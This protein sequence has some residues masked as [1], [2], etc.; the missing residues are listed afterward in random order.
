MTW[1]RSSR[2]G[3]GIL[4]CML[5]LLCPTGC[6]EEAQEPPTPEADAGSDVGAVD[7]ADTQT[8]AGLDADAPSA[9]DQ[10]DTEADSEPD[11][12]ADVPLDRQDMGGEDPTED[13]G[14]VRVDTVQ[15]LEHEEIQEPPLAPTGVTAEAKDESVILRWD[16]VV[17]A[18]SYSVYWDTSSGVTTLGPNSI[19]GIA[20]RAYEHYDRVNEVTYFY[21]VTAVGPGGE[22]A[23]SDEVSATPFRPVPSPSE[24]RAIGSDETVTLTWR[25]TGADSYNIYW[26]LTSA[27]TVDGGGLLE[28]VVQPYQ[29]TGLTNEVP[30][31]FIL[32][33]VVG[34]R[35]SLPSD[36]VAATP[37]NRVQPLFPEHGA[38]WNQYVRRLEVNVPCTPGVDVGYESCQHGGELRAYYLSGRFNCD[39]LHASDDL[40][41]FE[42]HCDDSTAPARVVSSSLHEDT[43]VYDLVDPGAGSFRPNTVTVHEDDT[44][45]AT[46]ATTA[47]WHNPVSVDNDGGSIST[48]GAVVIITENPNAE[49]EVDA[50]RVTVSIAP[51]VVAQAAEASDSFLRAYD[52]DYPWV[53]GRIDATEA[54]WGIRLSDVQFGVV[55]HV[56]VWKG[57]EGGVA[58]D[59]DSCW[60]SHLGVF[61]NEDGGLKVGGQ[62]HRIEHIIATGTFLGPGVYLSGRY[63]RF[64]DVT[65]ANNERDGFHAER[66]D[67]NT[68]IG[69]TAANNGSSGISLRTESQNN[70]LANVALVGNTDGVVVG[71][72]AHGNTFANLA[73]LNNEFSGI[74]LADVDRTV[75]TG[76]LIVGGNETDCSVTGGTEPGL[77]DGT[78]ASSDGSDADL[79]ID[80]RWVTPFVTKVAT[81]DPF[82]DSDVDG[83]SAAESVT[84]WA[85]FENRYR[86]WGTDGSTR[87]AFPRGFA[88]R[89]PCRESGGC[90]IFDWRLREADKQL[91]DVLSLPTGDDVLTVSAISVP[92]TFLRNAVEL[93][94]DSRGNDNTL[95]ESGERCLFM[96]HIGS[97]QG[98]GQLATALQIEGG[99]TVEDVHL[100]EHTQH[101]VS[102]SC[103]AGPAPDGLEP[104]YVVSAELGDDVLASGECIPFRTMTQCFD[105]ARPGEVVWVAPGTYDEALGERFPI[106]IPDGVH[107]IGDEDNRGV[108]DVPTRIQGCEHIESNMYVAVTPLEGSAI[109]GF[110]IV[111]TTDAGGRISLWCIHAD[112]DGVE[113]ANNTCT[114][115]DGGVYV[116]TGDNGATIRDNTF[117]SMEDSARGVRVESSVPCTVNN[118]E[119][120]SID[121]PISAFAGDHII[122]DNVINGGETGGIAG[123]SI[124]SAAP[125]VRG[126][127]ITAPT[128]GYQNA[129]LYISG[130]TSAPLIR[131]N[132]ITTTVGYAVKVNFGAEPDLGRLDDPGLNDFTAATSSPI[133]GVSGEFGEVSVQAIGNLWPRTPVCGEDIRIWAPASFIWGDSGEMCS[134]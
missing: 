15:D 28:N 78:C 41:A 108:G 14:D 52:S 25:D 106:R 5:G 71:G 93:S 88:Q 75:F 90:R 56:S 23:P 35:E 6:S 95:C 70:V 77:I 33:A 51:D 120:D 80:G 53:E 37:T 113:V 82:N 27:V 38:D 65:V 114:E 126:N 34:G 58:L 1:L 3:V 11:G 128:G 112:D 76:S 72:G 68:I 24:V 129:A 134:D 10:G 61:Q 64:V 16:E 123:I 74:A 87:S 46:S 133:V 89:G 119:F 69:L 7:Q 84:D 21:I 45:F 47:W 66:S 42:W 81:D 122:E 13:S 91:R 102:V 117:Q 131:E 43:L 118:N 127:T 57:N 103:V 63:N 85:S 97:Y 22:S 96:G 98:D 83:A 26:S 62:S 115:A 124:Q 29:R 104:D 73:S 40:D 18:T 8:D 30:V 125:T 67:D 116:D 92:I 99:G 12:T 130:G 31:Y 32:T 79:E 60:A 19:D 101:A 36:E 121:R 107:L 105:V 20:E 86:G 4:V 17:G 44:V 9:A 132:V 50:D 49:Y 110:S 2:I 54:D 55:R 59:G 100:V 111:P 48:E 94:N 109:S 39:G